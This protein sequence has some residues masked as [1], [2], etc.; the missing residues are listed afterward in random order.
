MFDADVPRAA[1]AAWAATRGLSFE[2]E[3]LL[4]PVSSVLRLS[5][6]VGS[7][8]AGLVTRQTEHG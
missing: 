3:G 5:L 4:P 8:I 6:G 1:L 2:P 7:R